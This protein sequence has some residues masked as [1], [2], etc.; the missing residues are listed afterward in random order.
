MDFVNQMC[1][2]CGHALKA[3]LFVL[4]ISAGGQAQAEEAGK[5]RYSL[6][7]KSATLEEAF[8]QL[9]RETGV[10]IFIRRNKAEKSVKGKS[11]VN[12]TF[13]QIVR[14]L[15]RNTNH[16]LVWNFAEKKMNSVDIWLFPSGAAE[17]GAP[18]APGKGA[19][20]DAREKSKPP[21]SKKKEAEDRRAPPPKPPAPAGAKALQRPPGQ[22]PAVGKLPPLTRDSDTAATPEESEETKEPEAPGEGHSAEEQ[23][24]AR[25]N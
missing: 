25:E 11:Y 24:E 16:I 3:L 15:L 14:D 20:D 17:A 9:A 8:K 23:S 7:I 19:V 4:V 13:D 18:P 21:K 6:E 5:T 1:A 22:P 12:E 10:G 2:R